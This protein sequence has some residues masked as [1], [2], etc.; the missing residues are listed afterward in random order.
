MS[1]LASA[2][3]PMLLAAGITWIVSLFKNDVSIV[4]S[5]WSIFFIIAAIH[6]AT[7]ADNLS[8]RAWIILL[9]VSLWGI[10]LAAH[11]SWRHWGHE[12]DH[13]YQ[14]IRNNNQPNFA[15]KSLYIIFCF[16]A[17]VAW[18]ISIPLFYAINASA[19]LGLLDLLGI[20]LWITGML[21][22]S[23]ADYQLLKFKKNP[24]NRGKI[25]TSGLWAY[26]R[27]PNYFGECLIWWGFFCFAITSG[28]LLVIISPLLM[29]FLLL[30]FSG[31]HLLE[32]TMKSRPGYE[33][34]MQR[35]N[36]F[37]PGFKRG[38]KRGSTT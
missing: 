13:R 27:H 38:F 26:S 19:S 23:V 9:L 37:I 11:I 24:D 8:T 14:Q 21:F 22:E 33:A 15:L 6:Y 1:E 32:K 20:S 29:T 16:Q 31:V 2:L 36:A 34:Y 25:L 3:Y 12:E 4:D 10:R 5:L 7:A 18:I 35:T 28:N 17:L 30:K